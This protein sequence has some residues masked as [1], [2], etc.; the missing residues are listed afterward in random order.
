MHLYILCNSYTTSERFHTPS[1]TDKLAVIKIWRKIYLM[2]AF[3][4]SSANPLCISDF[5]SFFG[6][7][8]RQFKFK[9]WVNV[10]TEL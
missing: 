5:S 1:I 3:V 9:T 8:K 6:T 2:H 10:L 4:N 7:T